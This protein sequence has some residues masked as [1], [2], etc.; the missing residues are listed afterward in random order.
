MD[1]S[2][3]AEAALY[4]AKMGIHAYG[5][6]DRFGYELLGYRKFQPRAATII[7]TAP[8]RPG[9]DG[10][11]V[12]G[13]QPVEVSI[14]GTVVV[15][16]TDKLVYPWQ[17]ADAPGRYFAALI[18]KYP[19][20]R[21][22]L[23]FVVANAGQVERVLHAARLTNAGVVAVRVGKSSSDE[24]AVKDAR[25]LAEW[26]KENPQ[27][28]AILFHTALYEPGYKLFFDFPKQVTFGDLDPVVR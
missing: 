7:G 14:E 13:N 19:Q 21:L 11:A 1:L 23:V 15:Q 4:L 17:Y 27:H 6:A 8:I 10:T 18:E 2:S 3:K 9:P 25:V 22:R 16:T 26:L 28:R 5:P 12:I 24:E 20:L